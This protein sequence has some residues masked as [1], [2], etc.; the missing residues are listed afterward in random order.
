MAAQSKAIAKAAQ[1]LSPSN[2]SN[3]SNNYRSR[4]TPPPVTTTNRF[5]NYNRPQ[6]RPNNYTPPA[7]RVAPPVAP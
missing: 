5:N 7:P 2:T 1:D 6:P 4:Y 3:T